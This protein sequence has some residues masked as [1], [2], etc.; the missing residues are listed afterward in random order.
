MKIKY[1]FMSALACGLL[2]ACNNDEVVENNADNNVSL[3]GDSY[4]AIRLVASNEASTRASEGNPAFELGQGDE[5]E[6]TTADFY[7]YDNAGNF[8]T[9]G[10]TQSSFTWDDQ[11]SGSNVESISNVMVVLENVTVTPTQV[12]A[13]LNGGSVVSDLTGSNM[14]QALATTISAYSY[15]ANEHDYF[16]MSNSAYVSGN[17]VKWATPITTANLQS[18]PELAEAN[19]VNIYVER[20][21][22]KVELDKDAQFTA[23]IDGDIQVD[24][25]DADL[26][27]T[28]DG[29]GLSG[30]N[31]EAYC[32]K[33][34]QNT[35]YWTGWNAE[36]N[37]RSYWA[38][39]PNYSTG[40]YPSDYNGWNASQANAS[41]NYL[42]YNQLTNDLDTDAAYCLE[43]TMD[44]T[45]LGYDAATGTLQDPAVTHLLIAATLKVKDAAAQ[46]LYRYKGY[47]YTEANY[48]NV[49]LSDW[50]SSGDMIY[51]KTVN[52]DKTTYTPLAVADI[53]IQDNHEGKVN[54]TLSEEALA[55]TWYRLTGYNADD[56]TATGET[57]V[58]EEELAA[59]FEDLNDADGF[60]EGKMYYCV[61]I[62]HLN[63][64]KGEVG[65]YGVVRNHLYRLTL[66]SIKNIGT[67][68]YNPNEV[69]IPNY[70][71]ETYYVAARL[72]I[73]SWHIVD[74]SV[75]L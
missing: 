4:M 60:K 45:V 72:N 1:L 27:V 15:N 67:A 35:T 18:S 66:E 36:A 22:A 57:A 31:K 10:K 69:I 65:S 8:V 63:T 47:F 29:W 14:T 7:F 70:E 59:L 23:V 62:E 33:N 3:E 71:P 49:T 38:E 74:Q 25:A 39:D 37:Y 34:I 58:E 16:V 43:N 75:N 32:V 12:L 68:V 41:L 13:V 40:N 48:K 6:V 46:T 26:E 61:P 2:G 19:P 55:K 5:N 20:V 73:L 52:D 11:T 56:G 30:T 17:E 44:K 28:V 50:M 24:G 9:K 21:A 64:S 53:T 54:I 42:T 51:T